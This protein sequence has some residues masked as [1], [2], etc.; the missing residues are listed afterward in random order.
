M[1]GEKASDNGGIIRAG[2]RLTK[3][4]RH[5]AICNGFFTEC[6]YEILADD[7]GRQ[8]FPVEIEDN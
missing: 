7:L 1:G 4:F 5:G 6:G 3:V 8:A 2:L